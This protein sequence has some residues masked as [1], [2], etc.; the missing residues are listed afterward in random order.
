MKK[1]RALLLFLLVPLWASACVRETPERKAAQRR[2]ASESTAKMADTAGPVATGKVVETMDVDKYTYVQLD[3]GSEKIWAAAPKCAVKVG[4]QL[5]VSKAMPMQNWHS[6]GLNRD[7]DVLYLVSSFQSGAGSPMGGEMPAGHPPMGG[8][9]STSGSAP[10]PN[11]DFTGLAKPEGG[12]TVA[13]IF[14]GKADLA[15]K[16]VT[17][18]GKVVKYNAQIMGKN[19]LHIQDGSG[20]AA[21]GT[22][23]LT[24]TTDVPT[25]VGDTVLVTGVVHLD[26]DIGFGKPYPVIIEDAKVVVE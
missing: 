18:R 26:K 21:A 6:D 11:I 1:S 17:V 15:N 4:D 2:E 13:E 7:F 3:T 8:H 24:V 20:D 12:M 9:P 14:A 22:N 16:E 10:P 25:K 19:W 23:D 5:T